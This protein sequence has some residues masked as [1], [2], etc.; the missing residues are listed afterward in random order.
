MHF[1]CADLPRMYGAKLKENFDRKFPRPTVL[2]VLHNLASCALCF[3]LTT[4]R[5]TEIAPHRAAEKLDCLLELY[6]T[7]Q[8]D[9]LF[10]LSMRVTSN[11]IPLMCYKSLGINDSSSR[12]LKET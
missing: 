12:R 1:A 2:Q 10:L 5:L 3:L 6:L 8:L 9:T 11:Y 4:E 7:S